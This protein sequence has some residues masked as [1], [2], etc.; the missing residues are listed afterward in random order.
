MVDLDGILVCVGAVI[1]SP[2]LKV[3]ESDTER[4]VSGWFWPGKKASESAA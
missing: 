1:E 4:S 3:S 2:R